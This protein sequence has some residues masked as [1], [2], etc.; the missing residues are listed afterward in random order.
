MTTQFPT[1]LDDFTNP[2]PADKLS[3][4]TVL[5]SD[6][7]S[8]ENDAI[9]ALEKKVGV[10][11]SADPSS[12]EYRVSHAGVAS[13]DPNDPVGVGASPV[14][15][16]S[17]SPP[18]GD[19]VHQ[20]VHGVYTVPNSALFGD[21]EFAG[22]PN[23]SIT[24]SSGSFTFASSGSFLPQVHDING[25][26]HDGIPLRPENG[27]TGVN[28]GA[29][30]LTVPASGTAVL[31]TRTVGTTSPLSGG[32]DLSADLT[33]S[34]PK[35][36]GSADGYLSALD[37]ITFN[38]AAAGGTPLDT[39]TPLDVAGAAVTG[40][41]GS[42]SRA[43]HQH[44]GVRGLFVAP[45]AA[46]F[47]DIALQGDGDITVSQSSGSF[48]VGATS[49]SFLP[50][51]HDVNG[52]Y[53]DGFP[54]TPERG[55][56]GVDNG[57][58]KLTIPATGTAVLTV[59]AIN[60]TAPLS[61]GGDLSSDRT[62][63]M[64]QADHVTNGY[65]SSADWTSFNDKQ[66]NLTPFQT[67]SPADVGS[68]PIAGTSGSVPHS[69]HTHQGVHGIFT[70]PNSS[71]YGDI[72]LVAGTN[73]T[74][75]QS[76]GSFAIASPNS[77]QA[78]RAINTTAPLQGGGDLSA[79][80]TLSIPQSSHA[81]DGYL[82]AT[83]WTI[84]NDKVSS[85]TP[86][87]TG[88]PADV[89]SAPATGTSGSMSHSDHVHQ[90]VHGLF[91]PSSASQYGNIALVGSANIAVTQSS[92]SFAFASSGSFLPLTH[93]IN[94]QYHDG[95]PLRTDRGGLGAIISPTAGA[96]PIGK[97]DGTYAPNHLI[98]GTNIGIT[99]TSGSIA[100][101]NT[102][103][104]IDSSAVLI[105]V[106]NSPT[107]NTEEELQTLTNSA[108][109]I[110]ATITY[111]TRQDSTHINVAAG[112]GLLRI[113]NSPLAQI[114]SIEWAASNNIAIPAGTG[115]VDTTRFVGIE[116]NGGSPQVAVR[117]SFDW[118]W[119][120]DFPLA[121]V[122]QDGTTLRIINTYAHSEDTANLA[123]RFNRLNLPFIREEP[124]EGSGGLGLS[125]V[126]SGSNSQY[127]G[128]TAGNMWHGFNRYVLAAVDTTGSGRFD[129]HYRNGTGGF[130]NVINQQQWDNLHYD[131]G[132]G[133]LAT[134][135]NNKYAVHWAYVDVSDGSLDLIFG[136]NQYNTSVLAQ[137]EGV[138]S[139]LPGHIQ[140][141]GRLIG[142]IIFQKGA[143]APDL[144]QSAFTTQF[145]VSG[146]TTHNELSGLQGGAASEYYHLTSAEYSAL[147]PNTRNIS[148]T[149][150]LT[151]GGNLS[152]DRALAITK[153][154]HVTDG[155]LSAVDWTTF[156]G[157]VSNAAPFATATPADVAS[158]AVTGTSG[159]VAYSDH[160][161]RGVH[162]L[163]VTPNSDQYGDIALVGG[164]NISITQSSG[165]FTITNTM[166]AGGI[167]F[168]PAN[169]ANVGS[170]AV[171]GTSGSPSHGDHA[172]QGVHGLFVAPNADQY[173]DISL[174]GST[175]IAVTQSS[176]SFTFTSS[177]SFLPQV[178]DI[179]GQY[180]NGAPLMPYNG[181]TGADNGTNALTIPATGT[182]AL[183]GTANI[184]TATQTIGISGVGIS[185]ELDLTIGSYTAS[186]KQDFGDNSLRFQAPV[187]A[188]IKFYSP[189][190][191]VVSGSFVGSGAGFSV[192]TG[193]HFSVSTGADFKIID[194]ASK[195]VYAD[196]S[197]F[198]TGV[199]SGSQY[200]LLQQ[201]ATNPAFTSFLI[202]GTSG[203]KTM[204]NVTSGKVLTLTAT[205]T[206]TLTIDGTAS[207]NGVNTGDQLFDTGS[208]SDIGGSA[209]TGTSGSMSHADHV[210][211]G[212]HGV[213]TAPNT[214]A[215]GDIALV[216]STNITVT[217]SSGSFTFASS[218]SFLPQVHDINGQYHNGTPLRPENGGTGVNNGTFQLTIPA[219]GT[220]V[221]TTRTLTTSAPLSGGGNLSA[222][223]TLS[224]PQASHAADGYLSAADWTTFNSKVSNAAPFATATPPDVA[225]AAVTGTSG[226]AAYS[227]H[228][229][230]G[231][232]GLFVAPNANTY[233]GVQLVGSANIAIT[234]SSGSFTFSSSGSFLPQVHDI[235]GQYHNGAPL[236]PDNGG[237][238][239]N[240]GTNKLTIPAT[241][242]AALGA[243]TLTVSTSN[244]VTGATHTHAITSSA[245]PGVAAA[246]LATN[247]SGSMTLQGLT[248][249]QT[250]NVTGNAESSSTTTGAATIA[251]GLGVAK[252]VYIGGALLQIG[253][254]SVSNPVFTINGAAGSVRDMRFMSAGV[255][256][257]IFRVDNTAESGS[258]AGS[259]FVLSS[260]NDAGAALA[261]AFT[262]TRSNSSINF[263]GTIDSSSSTTGA[264]TTAG[265]LGVAKKLYV[266]SDLSIGGDTTI[267]DAKNIVLNTTTGTKIGTA[268]TQKLGFY[269]ATPI[270]RGTAFT[271]TYSTAATTITQTA[272]TDPAAYG[273]GTNGYSTAGQASAIHAEVIALKANMV[274]TQN[275]L[276][277]VIDQLQ[278][279][280]LF[281]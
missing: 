197:G 267:A 139:S 91:V 262:V 245:A 123:R 12:L 178:H 202:D 151:G 49:G 270:V 6:Q 7:H 119:Y 226:S 29:N 173:G 190:Q 133:T 180:H 176:G 277:G 145:N 18:H 20:G 175:N 34:I 89:G 256:R 55:G 250:L 165:S 217:Q 13:F 184:F 266:G 152:A 144:V 81:A 200:S 43:D 254:D 115:G 65:L 122:S 57:T 244:D 71:Q 66:G 90:G 106:I 201:G 204:L 167:T 218:G 187:G 221:L 243:G 240:N 83:D 182:A 146:V 56:T 235:N 111:V 44:R 177:G 249:S 59:R 134:M 102:M 120:T 210:H 104:T 37:W 205:D 227:D 38:N 142:R 72:A 117:T 118:N 269:N 103:T 219:T 179:N 193:G 247:S 70:A 137:A 62:L 238:G 188:A 9:E 168:D 220:A 265:G 170:S 189:A 48:T 124:P 271:Q 213:Y 52:E 194:L 141:H 130:T 86:F 198:L 230:R 21:V 79:D 252:S 166:A 76:S 149:A 127:I 47:G 196:V 60:T 54:L 186:I 28:N 253:G 125:S 51:V 150:P 14:V 96:I 159:S 239:I 68:A 121:R 73:V 234:Q 63:F 53:H 4:P 87:D 108:G 17:G 181:G 138:P 229:H 100:I 215:F 143:V 255:L 23:I 116:Y 140:Y 264:V 257:W 26:Y 261:T 199:T 39:G 163:F 32:G 1:G 281:G 214:D 209:V 259:D 69:D 260:R 92:G 276:N 195:L 15:G 162:G 109:V 171:V 64:P 228:V 258:N 85:A 135:T 183:L 126:T 222:D 132:S 192:Q 128:M 174:V 95:Y 93:D 191:F 155:Y 224:I 30:T 263:G 169:P 36:T 136:Y 19:H 216:G 157:K 27:G 273:A 99:N 105:P 233:G 161:H 241:G 58:N 67:D 97:G 84:F 172:H 185:P 5:H 212:V 88:A 11:G 160:A 114:V 225:A 22:S 131:D 272:M 237:T 211:R 110:D 75:T 268:T 246:L 274:V 42:A 82:S 275:V 78:T 242:T 147:T 206:N 50:Q 203:G 279:L 8:N 101:S 33:L 25:A 24:Q 278:A 35:A 41:S 208:P 156:N 164:T 207:V 153:S 223:R 74:V 280:G 248:I 158:V 98:A 2:T 236:R 251:G 231:V 80:R 31:T 40:T 3:T 148:T 46:L 16:T 77:V 113:S 10:D 94:G 112:R 129:S 107:Y 61:G 45:D 232:T 154:S